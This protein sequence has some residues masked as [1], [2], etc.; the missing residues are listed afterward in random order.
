MATRT[1]LHTNMRSEARKPDG[2]L[3]QWSFVHTASRF[4]T[5][6]L[7]L[8]RLS[9]YLFSIVDVTNAAM[10]ST[11]SKVRRL[12]EAG[13]RRFRSGLQGHEV[14]SWQSELMSL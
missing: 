13:G 3:V 9:H 4:L 10:Q 8:L 11:P 12:E 5:S 7:Q 6:V 2:S 14:D 1:D